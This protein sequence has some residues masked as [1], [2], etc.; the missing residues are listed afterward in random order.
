MCVCV[1]VC[2]NCIMQLDDP[3]ETAV[4]NHNADPAA[5][6]AAKMSRRMRDAVQSAPGA[7]P[8]AV[9]ASELLSAST[10]ARAAI[11]TK[12]TVRRR[13]RRQ[14]RGVQPAEPS[15]LDDIELP[16]HFTMTGESTPEQFLIYDS[17]PQESK[18][19]LVFSSKG[20]LRHLAGTD[21]YV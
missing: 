8:T 19:M 13:L 3:H 4:H 7:R 5:V 18:R 21:R 12:E 2:V 9:L 20:Q 14:K 11:G 6:E 1:C 10:A 17:G 15:T 16:E